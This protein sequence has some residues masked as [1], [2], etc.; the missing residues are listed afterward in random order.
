MA[1]PLGQHHRGDLAQ[2][3][4]VPKRRGELIGLLPLDAALAVTGSSLRLDGFTRA[5]VIEAHFLD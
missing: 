3:R 2:F 4:I 5:Q 1:R